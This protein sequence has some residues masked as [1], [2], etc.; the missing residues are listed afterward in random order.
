MAAT[1]K[2]R[3]G[4]PP[5]LSREA[6]VQHTINL[7]QKPGPDKEPLGLRAVARECGIAVGGLYRYFDSLTDLEDDV[8]SHMLDRVQTPSAARAEPLREQL[9][10]LCFELSTLYRL[11]PR[12]GQL[13]NQ[14][15]SPRRAA[16][17]G[18]LTAQILHALLDAGISLERGNAFFTLLCSLAHDWGVQENRLKPPAPRR[19]EQKVIMHNLG[20]LEPEIARLNAKHGD[21][22]AQ[23]RWLVQHYIAALLPELAAVPRKRA[24]K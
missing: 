10:S 14:D 7:L 13:Y 18:R 19:R 6:I 8:A 15:Y 17:Q 11:H 1:K 22:A 23:R 20:D 2:K 24:R 4:R 21:Q 12:L 3:P 9:V 16:S 5:A